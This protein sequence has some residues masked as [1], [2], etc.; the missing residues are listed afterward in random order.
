MPVFSS[1]DTK[2]DCPEIWD[3]SSRVKIT[4]P[5]GSTMAVPALAM[6]CCVAELFARAQRQ[7]QL[8]GMDWRELLLGE[9]AAAAKKGRR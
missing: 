1:F 7:A 5:E 8:D 3:E 6:A 9:P 4:T 2:F